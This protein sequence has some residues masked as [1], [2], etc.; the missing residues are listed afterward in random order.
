MSTCSQRD[1]TMSR[2][3]DPFI[4]KSFPVFM[5][6]VRLP[7]FRNGCPQRSDLKVTMKKRWWTWCWRLC[8]WWWKWCVVF[9]VSSYC[10]RMTLLTHPKASQIRPTVVTNQTTIEVSTSNPSP[11]CG[12]MQQELILITLSPWPRLAARLLETKTVPSSSSAYLEVR[13]RST[14]SS[15]YWNEWNG[16][17][18][19]TKS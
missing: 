13:S 5:M 12:Q 15:R 1:P 8:C 11:C 6:Y 7:A 2:L 3:S 9:V 19:F 18:K 17:E 10:L 4:P 14:Y 16:H